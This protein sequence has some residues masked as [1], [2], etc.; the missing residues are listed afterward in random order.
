MT[1]HRRSVS[2]YP[3]DVSGT[4]DLLFNSDFQSV[5]E[6]DSANLSMTDEDG[7]NHG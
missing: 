1:K 5:I 2:P 6:G 7:V 3:E 4:F